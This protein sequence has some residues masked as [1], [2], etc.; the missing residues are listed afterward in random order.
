MAQS[1][2]IRVLIADDHDM[3]RCGLSLFIYA[4][5]DLQLVGEACNGKEAVDLCHRLQ[6]DVVLMDLM[7]PELDGITAI[8]MI[9]DQ[10][11]T[12][13]LIALSSFG[14][15]SMVTA[16]LTAGALSYL[17]KNVSVDEL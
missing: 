3:L 10:Q 6:P 9:H 7:M 2:V 5:P 4:C 11:P 13:Q 14:D 8:R 15:E 16:A 12:V 17:L 1:N